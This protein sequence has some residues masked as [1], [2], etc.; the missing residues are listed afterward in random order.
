MTGQSFSPILTIGHSLHSESQ[1]INFLHRHDVSLVID[2]RSSPYS[3]HA[4]QYNR[5]SFEHWLSLAGIGYKFAGAVLGGRPA[6]HN[7]YEGGQAS[8]ERMALSSEFLSG[9]RNVA[10]F[11]KGA[12]PV[13]VC[14]EADPIECHRFLLISRILS[15]KGMEVRHI[16]PSGNVELQGETE[17][18]LM[19]A[20]G[21]LQTGFFEGGTRNLSDAYA[22]Q[23]SRFAYTI[24]RPGTG[25]TIDDQ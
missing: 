5:P 25:L 11:A 3:Q 12:R 9:L 13:L 21:L 17:E 18:R 22:I 2:V 15:E 24:P 14:A 10:R 8:Y 6:D 19:N 23:S 1:F 20:T 7:L 16:L 4:P